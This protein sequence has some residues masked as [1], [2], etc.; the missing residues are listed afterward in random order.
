MYS[1]ED[2]W[3]AVLS[4]ELWKGTIKLLEEYAA[5]KQ[6]RFTRTLTPPDPAER[7]CAIKFSDGNEHAYGAV[8]MLELQPWCCCEAS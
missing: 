5:L 3:D 7:P 1:A 2:S 6:V 4:N 8:L